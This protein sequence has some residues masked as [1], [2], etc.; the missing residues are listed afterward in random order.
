MNTLMTKVFATEFWQWHYTVLLYDNHNYELY[1]MRRPIDHNGVNI[2]LSA[3]SIRNNIFRSD[4]YII[5]KR[6]LSDFWNEITM[7][8]LMLPE[9]LDIRTAIKIKQESFYSF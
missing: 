9:N 7:E 5:I 2:M 8:E 1:E 3:W 4:N 6:E